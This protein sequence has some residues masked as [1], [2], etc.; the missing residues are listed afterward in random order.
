MINNNIEIIIFDM[1]DE[2]HFN[3]YIYGQI[4]GLKENQALL[5][6]M[7]KDNKGSL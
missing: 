3:L 5:P 1:S 2:E 6:Q 4:L 7:A